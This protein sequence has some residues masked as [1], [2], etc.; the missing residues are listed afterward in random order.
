VVRA[1]FRV[2]NS[3]ANLES[4]WLAFPPSVVSVPR[5]S[6]LRSPE[7]FG[8]SQQPKP[9]SLALHRHLGVFTLHAPPRYPRPTSTVSRFPKAPRG[10]FPALQHLN[11]RN[12]SFHSPFEERPNRVA[13]RSGRHSLGFGYPLEVLLVPQ[14][15]RGLFQPPTLLGFTL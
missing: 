9:S 2:L 13:L 7:A 15:F 12:P 14:A 6:G 5:P 10:S 11:L 4:P 3:P 8:L 1:D